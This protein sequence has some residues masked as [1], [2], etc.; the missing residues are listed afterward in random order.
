MDQTAITTT[1]VLTFSGLIPFIALAVVA[2]LDAPEWLGL[3]LIA[4]GALILSFMAGTLWA[5]HLLSERTRP[6]PLIAS[7]A[8]VLAA[9]PAVL[10]PVQVAA[11]WLGLL[12]AAHLLLEKSWHGH[13]MPGWYGRLRMTVSIVAIVLLLS[14]GLVGFG[15]SINE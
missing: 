2:V 14:G 1:R 10:V 4:Y 7:N 3:L 15:V 11:I 12:F 8:L 6:T 9:W 5:Q 13:A